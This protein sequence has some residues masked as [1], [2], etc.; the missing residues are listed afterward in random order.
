MKIDLIT[1]SQLEVIN[2]KGLKYPLADAEKDYF[3]AIILKIIY[4]S[5]LG[6]ILVFKGGTAIYHCYLEQFR[7][8]KDLDF[9]ALQ[10]IDFAEIKKIFEEYEFLKVKKLGEKKYGLDFSV[11]Y[12]GMLLRPNSIDI[13]INKNQ[14]VLSKTIH[15][16]YHNNYSLNVIVK[17]MNIKEIVAEKIR[18][19]NERPRPRDLYDLYL[20][21]DNYKINLKEAIDL[22]KQNELFKPLTKENINEN[23]R[24][25]LESYE[26]DLENLYYRKKVLL[27]DIKDLAKGIIKE[28]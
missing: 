25:A 28:I 19:L 20:L 6:D 11:Q 5:F 8:S 10:L 16:P 2:K 15:H 13:N 9:A 26:S 23:V 4:N 24:I 1:R 21:I 3:L 18:T 17:L 22:L 12:Q 7:F 14:K 27:E